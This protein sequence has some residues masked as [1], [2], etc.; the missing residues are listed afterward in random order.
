M[1]GIRDHII[2]KIDSRFEESITSAGGLS[3]F[4]DSTYNPNENKRIYGEVI[5]APSLLSK[6]RCLGEFTDGLPYG[7]RDNVK[8]ESF[9]YN[10]MENEV[11]VGDKLYFYYTATEDIMELEPGVFAMLYDQAICVVRGGAII[12]VASHILVKPCYGEGV[13]DIGDGIM[14][15][16]NSFGMVTEIN[17]KPVPRIGRVAY[18]GKP[19]KNRGE[20]IKQG[21][22]IL[23]DKYCEFKNEIE[24]SEYYVMKHENVFAVIGSS[25]ITVKRG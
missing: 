11:Q 13:E 3:L 22:L 15:K 6:D 4:L 21:D 23:F 12:P 25:D 20:N 10:E 17:C 19:L 8:P 16:T 9:G 2:F 18:A 1:K 14:G 5:A 24:G 7:N